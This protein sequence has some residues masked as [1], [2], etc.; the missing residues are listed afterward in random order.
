[1]N[2]RVSF[3]SRGFQGRR[4]EEGDS[5]RVPPGQ[6][7]VDDFPVLSAGPTP[8]TP[9]DEWSFT[10]TGEVAEPKTWT[11]GGVP[12]APERDDHE[13]HPL[14]HEVVQA[15]HRLGRGV[16]GHPARRG[17]ARRRVR[18]RVLRRRLHDEPAARGRQRRQGLG[19][20]RLRRRAARSRA[21]RA[22]PAAR[23]PPLLLEEREV[24]A[25]ARPGRPTTSRASGR[26][27]GTTSTETRGGSSGTGATEAAD[28][29]AL[30][31]RGGRRGDAAA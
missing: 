21:R 7:L 12:R 26:R 10:V 30:R 20:V 2:A 14:R 9:L 23:P 28:V 11:V 17:R 31:R 8:H 29:A 25:R 16:G 3:V 13:G 27:W 22:R 4:R 18:G 24:G 5:G 1:M 6:Y 15:R 19:R